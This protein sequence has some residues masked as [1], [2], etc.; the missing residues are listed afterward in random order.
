MP[1]H[2]VTKRFSEICTNHRHWHAPTHCALIHGYARSVELTFACEELKEGWV[3]DL[4]GL[5][6]LRKALEEAW[7][8]K[9][10]IASDDPLLADIQAL[11]EKGALAVTVMDV[12][13]GHGPG[14]EESCRFVAD[15]AA[16]IVERLA[17]ARVW[18]EKVEI[19]EK[20]DNRAALLLDRPVR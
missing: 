17:G 13:R 5:K 15:L 14:L 4:G 3:L 18:I 1:R 19:W 12:T 20:S 2:T 16:P 10:L 11:A 6:E 7:D 9:T 8:H